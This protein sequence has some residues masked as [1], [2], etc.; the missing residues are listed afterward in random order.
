[1]ILGLFLLVMQGSM[2]AAMVAGLLRSDD[3]RGVSLAAETIWVSAGI[4]WLLYA[5]QTS[6]PVLMASGTLAAV[7]S[8]IVS[9]LVWRDHAGRRVAPVAWGV[10]VL[11]GGIVSALVST[12]AL[13]VGLAAFGVVQFFP[14]MVLSVRVLASGATAARSPLAGVALRV[15]YTGLWAVFA[16]TGERVDL[17][18]VAWGATGVVAFGLQ[19]AAE[20]RSRRASDVRDA[21]V[22]AHAQKNPTYEE[23][24]Q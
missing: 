22:P 14:Q 5:I 23:V 10:G 8:A 7:G 9:L 16:A 17:P 11:A 1:M 6:N 2:V 21:Q 19:V 12:G 24:L 4:G 20:L 13:A 15:V 18:L 3:R